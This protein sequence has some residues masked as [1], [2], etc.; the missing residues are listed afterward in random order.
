[1][2]ALLKFDWASPLAACWFDFMDHPACR[3]STFNI[4]HQQTG[5]TFFHYLRQ[6]ASPECDGGRSA[7]S[8]LHGH[9]RAG[10]IGLAGDQ[11]RLRFL[12]QF[13]F[14]RERRRGDEA[15][16]RHLAG[17]EQLPFR[18]L[19]MIGEPIDLSGQNDR[20][21]RA[22]SDLQRQVWS[23]LFTDAPSE[24]TSPLG[25]S[26][27]VC[28]MPG[29]KL[30]SAIPFGTAPRNPLRSEKLRACELETQLKRT[31]PGTF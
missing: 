31:L 29:R 1:M 19:L 22:G 27:A 4:F 9:Q 6:R 3:H 23:F 7:S 11:E 16:V 20:Q 28:A 13:A 2:V 25:V 15:G 18:I 5:H 21:S 8:S 26:I 10:L 12:Q 24:K 14:L 17:G 30:S